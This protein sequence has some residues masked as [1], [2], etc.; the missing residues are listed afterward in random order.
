MSLASIRCYPFPAASCCA[1]GEAA[2]LAHHRVLDVAS[3]S[4]DRYRATFY[5]RGAAVGALSW[6]IIEDPG[7]RRL[8][9]RV[10]RDAVRAGYDE[11]GIAALYG[12]GSY[13]VGHVML[14]K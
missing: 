12:D 8:R 9:P 1:L 4:G 7:L 3:D 5:L 14:A 2:E 13:S 11:V 6:G 10:P